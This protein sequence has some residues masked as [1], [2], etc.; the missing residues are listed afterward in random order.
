MRRSTEGARAR[1]QL[2][3]GVEP[4]AFGPRLRATVVILAAMLRS[5]RATLTLLRDYVRRENQPRLDRETSSSS[6]PPRLQ[7]SQR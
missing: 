7:T 3:D 2:P 4:G 6:M 1:A 5:R